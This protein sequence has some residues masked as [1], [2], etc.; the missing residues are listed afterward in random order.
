MKLAARHLIANGV[1]QVAN[2][3]RN[4]QHGLEL[5]QK[6]NSTAVP[7]GDYKTELAGAD[8]GLVSTGRHITWSRPTM[9]SGPCDNE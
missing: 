8:I 9:C 3:H 6:F 4:F 1:R 5:A 2:H 7:F